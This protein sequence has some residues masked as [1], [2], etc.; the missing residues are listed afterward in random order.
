MRHFSYPDKNECGF[1]MGQQQRAQVFPMA[2]FQGLVAY[3]CIL[4]NLIVYVTPQ[5]LGLERESLNQDSNLHDALKDVL[6]IGYEKFACIRAYFLQI[7]APNLVYI[8]ETP[9]KIP[10]L[11]SRQKS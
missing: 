7:D 3:T 8:Q 6:C 4:W 1:Q 10:S 11:S 9:S 2:S 5:Y